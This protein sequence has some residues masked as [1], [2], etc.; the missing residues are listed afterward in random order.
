MNTL[1]TDAD[2]EADGSIKLLSPLPAWLKPGRAHVLLVVTEADS[3]APAKK[4]LRPS[5]TPEMLARRKA[6][7]AGLRALG[8]L[9]DAIPDPVAWQREIR[10][11][12]TLP[13]RG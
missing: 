5:A 8:G 7:Y 11:D 3:S 10:E 1:E 6:A 12:R 9:S 13:G 4:R 2:I